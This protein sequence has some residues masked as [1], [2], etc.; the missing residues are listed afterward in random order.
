MHVKT[1]QDEKFPEKLFSVFT[2]CKTPEQ[3]RCAERYLKLAVQNG[4]VRSLDLEIGS[5]GEIISDVRR[6]RP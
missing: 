3:L 6:A 1:T 5:N 4:F 2:G